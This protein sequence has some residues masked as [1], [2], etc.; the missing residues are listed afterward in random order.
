MTER[1][2]LPSQT[3]YSG[4]S[5]LT[6]FDK[7]SKQGGDSER[8]LNRNE[9]LADARMEKTTELIRRPEK[10]LQQVYRTVNHIY[11]RTKIDAPASIN[12]ITSM[13]EN[14]AGQ[15]WLLN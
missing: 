13:K 4:R 8:E 10:R 15:G 7:Q 3:I 12:Q 14:P 11:R 1:F 5:Y 6:G 2:E 9:F